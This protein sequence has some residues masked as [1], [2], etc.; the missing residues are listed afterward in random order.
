MTDNDV[1]LCYELPCHAQQSKSYKPQP[2][3][4]LIL[5]VY[6]NESNPPN[7]TAFSS[8]RNMALIGVP[9]IAVFNQEEASDPNVIYDQVID[10]LHRWT[11]NYYHL[12]KWEATAASDIHKVGQRILVATTS[13]SIKSSR[14]MIT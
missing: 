2:D 12:Y 14:V 5:P 10:R 1:I 4:P 7:R 8:T 6:I 13:I 11:R 3:D 9:T